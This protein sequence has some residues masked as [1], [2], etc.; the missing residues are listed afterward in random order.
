VALPESGA[1]DGNRTHGSSLGSLGI[2]IIRR[3][4]EAD[5]SRVIVD[6]ANTLQGKDA[7]VGRLSDYRNRQRLVELIVDG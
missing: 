5:S 4:L 2:T 7:H 1:G 3:P 6:Q